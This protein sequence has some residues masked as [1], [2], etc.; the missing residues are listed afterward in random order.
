[1]LSCPL[2]RS[3]AAFRVRGKKRNTVNTA[4]NNGKNVPLSI[5]G[6]LKFWLNLSG[7]SRS[8]KKS[9]FILQRRQCSN[10]LTF[11]TTE[12]APYNVNQ[13][14]RW[15][16]VFFYLKN[17]DY[18]E[19]AT[20]QLHWFFFRPGCLNVFVFF[21]RRVVNVAAKRHMLHML[22]L[23]TLPCQSLKWLRPPGETVG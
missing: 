7:D 1:M 17:F 13:M 4:K 14:L 23:V 5:A 10:N 3:I 21:S 19:I 18:S 6:S 11:S 16:H 12:C 20:W 8:S 2:C 15:Q 9:H 22:L